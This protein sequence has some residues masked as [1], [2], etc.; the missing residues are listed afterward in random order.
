MQR[1]LDPPFKRLKIA[2][3]ADPQ[4]P[5]PPTY[6]G[7]IERII[8]MLVE[9]LVKQG[10]QVSLFAHSESVTKA[11]LYPYPSKTN[12]KF[13]TL[14][15]MIFVN[16]ILLTNQFDIIHSFS[17]LAYL[18]PALFSKTP[19]IMSYQREPTI[20]QIKKANK[21]ARKNTLVFTGCSKYISD[22]ISPFA[23]SYTI[24]NGIDPAKYSFTQQ[25]DNA[26]PLIFLGRIEPIKGVHLAVEI[27]HRTDKDLII[28]GNISP[29]HQSYFDQKIS[30]HLSERIRYV[31]SVDDEQKKRL[32]SNSCALLMPII[33]D[34]PF[35]IVMVEAMAC[36]TP[37]IGLKRGAV[38]EIVVQGV[39]GYYGDTVN[40]LVEYVNQTQ[41]ISRTVVFEHYMKNFSSFV[42]IDNY[43]QLYYKLTSKR[44]EP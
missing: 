15:N 1:D 44:N 17:R 23:K 21:L 25:F 2:I 5:V 34:E 39:N 12:N 20:S 36:G 29:E 11:L 13:A 8:E 24:Y 31:G 32:L 18:L 14:K 10:H 40:E 7:G 30:P 37:V 4:I 28:C 26:K 38:P 19:K 9:G 33:W 6:Y 43:L 16:K 35:G 3:T 42:I 27:A 41:K 22:K